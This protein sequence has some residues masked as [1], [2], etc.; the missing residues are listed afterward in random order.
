MIQASREREISA[1]HTRVQRVFREGELI[2]R[3]LMG[4]LI[5]SYRAEADCNR[6]YVAWSELDTLFD[7]TRG[8]KREPER[9]IQLSHLAAIR[10]ADND[11]SA[12]TPLVED[13]T[14]NWRRIKRSEVEITC[15]LFRAKSR[16]YASLI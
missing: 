5:R 13:E 11:S 4:V 16:D 8:S 2:Q 1:V 9:E 7:I 6:E 3:E 15:A 12:I 14:R 10:G